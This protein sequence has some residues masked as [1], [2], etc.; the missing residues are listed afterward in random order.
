MLVLGVLAVIF[1]FTAYAAS[2]RHGDRPDGVL[3][4]GSC[5]RLGAGGWADEVACDSGR[6]GT[7]VSLRASQSTCP[8]GTETW[9]DRQSVQL[10]CVRRR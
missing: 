10:V 9:H 6:D 4:V 2:A 1:V 3:Q 5:V 8:A 7:V